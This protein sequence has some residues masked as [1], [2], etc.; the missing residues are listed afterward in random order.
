MER[1]EVGNLEASDHRSLPS[2]SY[3]DVGCLWKKY[4][5]GKRKGKQRKKSQTEDGLWCQTGPRNQDEVE[6]RPLDQASGI[7]VLTISTWMSAL[8]DKHN[9]FYTTYIKKYILLHHLVHKALYNNQMFHELI[10]TATAWK[11]KV[12]V[13]R[14]CLTLCDPMDHSL[15]VSS[16]HGI[17]QARILEWVAIAFSRGSSW[18]RDQTQVSCIAG[19]FFTIWAARERHLHVLF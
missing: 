4:W 17:L 9:S 7:S 2:W 11:W 3:F 1:E 8:P 5:M 14:S 6:K 16:V 10:S 13:T 18:P 19:R 12:L 15:P